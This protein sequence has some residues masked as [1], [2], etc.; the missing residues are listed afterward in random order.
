M[1]ETLPSRD[2][3]KMLQNDASTLLYVNWAWLKA[4]STRHTHWRIQNNIVISIN[5]E[6]NCAKGRKWYK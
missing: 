4:S 6:G 1:L 5:H 3:R 2:L